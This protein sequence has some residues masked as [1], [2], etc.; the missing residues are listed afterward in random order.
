MRRRTTI[1]CALT[2]LTVV[3]RAQPADA[4]TAV[5]RAF[6]PLVIAVGDGNADQALA[7]MR[8]SDRLLR[9]IE[10]KLE[11]DKPTQA[12]EDAAS[13][14]YEELDLRGLMALLPQAE[15]PFRRVAIRGEELPNAYRLSAGKG[16][17]E[18][19][20]TSAR[21]RFGDSSSVLRMRRVQGADDK[22]YLVQWRAGLGVGALS[23]QSL[24]AGAHDALRLLDEDADLAALRGSDAELHEAHPRLHPED[25]RVLAQSWASFP[26][27]A[28]LM[29][30]LTRCDDVIDAART[31][32]GLTRIRFVGRLDLERMEGGYPELV[33]YLEGLGD[34]VDLRMQLRDGAGNTLLEV[35][36]D[37]G[38]MEARIEA[39]V[40]QGELAPS[41]NGQPRPGTAAR[42][43]RTSVRIDVHGHALGIH[44]YVDDLRVESALGG[45]GETRSLAT[46]IRR[47]PGFR[48]EGRALG[49]F[50]AGMLDWF[51]PGDIPGLAK[52]MF[53]VA[54]KGNQGQGIALDF[55]FARPPE[56]LATVDFGAGVEVLDTA[57]I[58]FGMAIA[59]DR[60]IPD[61]DQRADM[62]KLWFAFRDALSADLERFAREVPR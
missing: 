5:W 25:R 37:S 27:L 51:I 29:S 32:P 41:R 11:R 54:G 42:Y 19:H 10:T 61:E 7:Y 4:L 6:R 48:V 35:W 34:L 43:E 12:F 3:A 8:A 53:E 62:S 60:I 23:W 52:R 50:P 55:R 17:F 22:R 40:A 28:R 57:L 1:V 45:E 47:T 2:V 30:S 20:A 39:Y 13:E 33:D 49:V 56:Q 9:K 38:R 18:V 31:R 21:R 36:L 24:S 15:G 59:A 26:G 14:S 46:R 58:R 16:D 44:M